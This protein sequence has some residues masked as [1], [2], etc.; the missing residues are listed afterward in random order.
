MSSEEKKFNNW[1][2]RLISVSEII[3]STLVCHGF[4]LEDK[5]L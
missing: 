2:N 3:P 1:C 5:V 4:S